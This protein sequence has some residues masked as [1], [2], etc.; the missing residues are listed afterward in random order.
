MSRIRVA[1]L[2]SGACCAILFIAPV[3]TQETQSGADAAAEMARKLQDPLANMSA[4][5]TDNDILFKTGDGDVSAQFQIQPVH[6]FDFL[7]AGFSFIARGVI[8][9]IDAAPLADLPPIGEPLPPGDSITWGIGDI[10]PR[11][12]GMPSMVLA[13]S[14]EGYCLWPSSISTATRSSAETTRRPAR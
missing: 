12:R 8:P 5:M 4:V 11:P 7:D 2:L 9:I 1:W 14:S 10:V 6:A 3:V 13:I